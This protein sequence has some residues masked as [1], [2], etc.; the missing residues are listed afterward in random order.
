MPYIQKPQKKSN[1]RNN[2]KRNKS[3]KEKLRIRLYN[4]AAWKRLRLG[5]LISHP[6]C[7]ICG[8]ELATD[9]HHINSPFDDG[10]SEE[11]RIGKL[12]NPSNLQALCSR[13][14]GTLHLRKQKQQ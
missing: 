3:A 5:Y 8:K 2:R 9:V 1:N 14:H 6:T 11:E 7:E 12:L 10:L 13:C 4:K